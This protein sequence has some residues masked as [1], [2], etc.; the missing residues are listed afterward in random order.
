V[1]GR[2]K[3]LAAVQVVVAAS[4]T[5]MARAG[6]GFPGLNGRIA[7]G[8][9]SGLPSSV[10]GATALSRV[11]TMN[12][13]GSGNVD[14]PPSDVTGQP[15]WS[16]DGTQLAF[17]RLTPPD[18]SAPGIFV[19][20]ADGSNLRRVTTASSVGAGG[21]HCHLDPAWSPDGSRI[22]YEDF[23]DPPDGLAVLPATTSLRMVDVNS[24][25]DAVFVAPSIAGRHL[26]YPSWSPDGTQISFTT[27]DGSS[28]GGD[29]IWTIEP[30]G[31]NRRQVTATESP[32]GKS[33]WSPDSKTLAFQ[34]GSFDFAEVAT[35]A[36][37]ATEA[38]PNHLTSNDHFDGYPTF[39]PDGRRIAYVEAPPDNP[40]GDE[41]FTMAAN[42]S[43]RQGP[44]SNTPTEVINGLSWQ[45]LSPPPPPPF[46]PLP[47]IPPPVAPT[48]LLDRGVSS[49]GEVPIALGFNFPPNTD[50][51]LTWEPGNGSAAAR[52]ATDGTFREQILVMPKDRLG[53]R[54]L[55]ATVAGVVV[56]RTPLLVVRGTFQPGGTSGA[57]LVHH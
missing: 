55:D 11:A 54:T 34:D 19:S 7:F 14:V 12:P 56:A 35:I 41:I 38:T 16:A 5:P 8:A 30:T 53:A 22:V 26:R 4:V 57:L 45:A 9:S 43:D 44:L 36:A 39:S 24:G 29:E 42:G 49:T 10:C 46:I 31:A 47:L 48:L 33:D 15:A 3:L 37:T 52:S 51:L 17:A 50:V 13:D 32:K 1:R 2:L 23:I 6:A 28:T 20:R 21:A 27:S 25:A 18:G 40:L